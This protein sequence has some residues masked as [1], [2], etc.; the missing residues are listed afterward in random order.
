[1]INSFGMLY[2]ESSNIIDEWKYSCSESNILNLSLSYEFDCIVLQSNLLC[3][4]IFEM[5]GMD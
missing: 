4:T 1:M 2:H 3:A 5:C